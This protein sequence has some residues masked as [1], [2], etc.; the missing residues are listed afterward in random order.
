MPIYTYECF[1]CE[2]RFEEFASISEYNSMDTPHCP[3]CDP[4][5]KEETT[6]FRFMGDVRPAFQVKGDGAFDTRMK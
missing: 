4:E 1:K 6:L 2:K 3:S 5:A